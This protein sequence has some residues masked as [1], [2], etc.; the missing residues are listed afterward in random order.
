ILLI[1]VHSPRVEERAATRLDATFAQKAPTPAKPV[2]PA[3]APAPVQVKPAKPQPPRKLLAMDKA[4]GRMASPATPK[5]SVAEKEEMNS[6]LRE[7]DGQA[8]KAPDLAQRS[9]AMAR[10]IGRQQAA[11][12]KEGSEVLERLPNS[13]PVDPFS[14][15]MYLDALVRKLNRSAGFVRNDPRGK[16]LKV[17][18]LEIRLNPNGSLKSFKVLNAADQQDEIAFVKSVVEQ[19]VPFSPFPPDISKA[20]KS[21][22]MVICIM[23]ANSSG[24]GFGFTRNPGGRGC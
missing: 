7:L 21:L 2:A 14:L 5:W 12:E 10:D 17:A 23:P 9:L 8:R 24:G 13:A 11:T 16:G 20:A 4:Q 19:S 22:A 1:P 15:E 6:F 3:I 18:S